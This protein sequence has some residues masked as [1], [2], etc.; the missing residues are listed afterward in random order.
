MSKY[1]LTNKVNTQYKKLR[2][3]VALADVPGV[4][5]KGD[6]GG[7]I[8]SESNLSQEGSCWVADNCFVFNS[9]KIL[10]NAVITGNVFVS[11]AAI[12]KNDS[13]IE[14]KCK[15]MGHAV[16]SGQSHLSGKLEVGNTIK[17]HNVSM[18]GKGRLEGNAEI[19]FG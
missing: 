13:V 17:L 10:D 5:S 15:I 14:G 12:V 3:I 19:T 8:E 11:D 1:A 2:Q 7:Y 9:A 18:S 6:F 16:I 4:C